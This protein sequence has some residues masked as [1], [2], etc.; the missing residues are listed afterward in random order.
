MRDREGGSMD[1]GWFVLSQ[2]TATIA[3]VQ[4]V[5]GALKIYSYILHADGKSILTPK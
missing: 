1:D 4:S 5:V 3:I 2:A